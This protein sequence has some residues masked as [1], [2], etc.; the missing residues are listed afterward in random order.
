MGYKKSILKKTL[1]GTLIPIVLVFAAAGALILTTVKNSSTQITTREL[2]AKS[3]AAAF[4]VSEFFTR[5][6]ELVKQLSANAQLEAYFKELTPGAN[7]KA[8]SHYEI[9]SQTLDNV[10]ATDSDNITL[11]WLADIDTGENIRSGGVVAGLPDFDIT[12]R[13]WYEP[14]VSQKKLFIT[15]PYLDN[16]TQDM[17]LS[18]LTPVFDS[19]T[20]ELIGAAAIDLSLKKVNA[21]MDTFTLGKTGFLILITSNG[22]ILHHP[23]DSLE[24]LNITES[25]LPDTLKTSVTNKLTGSYTYQSGGTLCYGYLSTAGNTGWTVLTGLPSKEFFSSYIT[26]QYTIF[27]IFITGLIILIAIITFITSGTV[28]PLKALS[29]TAYAIADGNLDVEVMVTSQDETGQLA[30]AIKRTVVR[31]KDYIKYIDEITLV[32]HDIAAGNLDFSLT[33]DYSG[34]FSKIK[35]A[36]VLISQN[37]T[38]TIT[39]IA[40]TANQVASGSSQISKSSDSLA[41]GAADQAGSIEELAAMVNEISGKIKSNSNNAK[42]SAQAVSEASAAIEEGNEK[43]RSMIAAMEEIEAASGQISNII[44][45]IEDIA[46]QTNLLSLNAAIEAA[47]AGEMGKGFAVVADEVRDLSG[48][49]ASAVKDTKELITKSS[50]AVSNGTRI[51]DSTAALL[52]SIVDKARKSLELT[53][54]ILDASKDQTAFVE[55]ISKGVEQISSV[56]EMNA[57]SSQES[58][59]TSRELAEQA[60]NLEALISNFKLKNK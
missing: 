1:L 59:K 21:M 30:D 35:D 48:D 15:D 51:A 37:L 58:A 53:S 13:S 32:L 19:D 26:V 22:I 3:E 31:L 8:Q 46:A 7:P 41:E 11:V 4:Q 16:A 36:L 55:Q 38:E 10:Q 2:T 34:D 44:S 47:R 40:E 6:T 27:L 29:A 18:I 17:V 56:I 25:D 14:L 28:K 57:A 42:M 23:D 39:R 24:G 50:Q 60:K 5:Y 52:M 49:S 43:M 9:V 33:Y 12:T 45:A 54:L 20:N